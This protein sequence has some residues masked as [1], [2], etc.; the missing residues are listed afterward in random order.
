M[1]PK[2]ERKS[3]FNIAWTKEPCFK[4]WLTKKDDHTGHC[5]ICD[6][7]IPI[8]SHARFDVVRHSK[9]NTHI[10]N[11]PVPIDDESNI[12]Q[13]TT[14]KEKKNDEEPENEESKKKQ[15]SI[16][17]M[18]E[19]D[20]VLDAEIRWTLKKIESKFSARSCD[21]VVELFKIMFS[22]SSI[23]ENMKLKRTK[24]GY[25]VRHGLGPYFEQLLLQQVASS[26]VY[27]LSFDESMNKHLQKGQMD[28]IIRFWNDE[29]KVP[30]TRY[31]TSEFMG[32]A[33]ADDIEK[34]FDSAVTKKLKRPA[35]LIQISSDGP[36]VNLLF[37]KNYNDKRDFNELPPLLNIGT[38]GLH[39]VHG[40]MKAGEK[41]TGWEIGKTL[42]AMAGLLQ[43]FPARRAKYENITETF[44]F[45]LPYCGHRWCE[46][47]KCLE[48]ADEIWPAFIK[49][50]KYLEKEPKSKQ[51]GKGEGKQF[52][53]LRKK[54][55]DPLIRAKMK[56]L[57]YVSGI[58]NEFLRGFQTDKPMVPFLCSTLETISRTLMGMFVNTSTMKNAYTLMSL[59]K[60]D[61]N[62]RKI[63]KLAED[64]DVGIGAKLYIHKYKK[65]AGFKQ[66]KLNEFFSGAQRFLS[67]LL[68]HMMK[69]SPLSQAFARHTISINPNLIVRKSRQ[70]LNIKYFSRILEK[71]VS[72]GRI[73]VKEGNDA[74][75][76]YL[77]LITDIVPLNKEK[78]LAFD[79]FVDRLDTFYAEFLD[80]KEFTALWKVFIIIF[81]LF[82]GQSAIE[83]GFNVNDALAVVNQ[84][85]KSLIALRIVDDYMK[86]QGV[87][88]GTIKIP[89]NLRKSFAGARKRSAEE[90]EEK[91]K[92]KQVSEKQRKRKIVGD[93]IDEVKKKK[94]F[95]QQTIESLHQ[96]A[97]KCAREA[98]SQKDF[99]LLE[100]S[101]DMRSAIHTKAKEIEELE[102]IEQDLV[103]RR[104]GIM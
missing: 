60:I 85:D 67:A 27:S 59:L 95:L 6:K 3:K 72:T 97:D 103:V 71:L 70:E 36:N 5:R 31:L 15:M 26:P 41:A 17:C 101:N 53:L 64:T 33:K 58:L 37:L 51:P 66:E 4:G 54:V 21:N 69:K 80:N 47:E 73:T 20:Q 39:T 16:S 49:F 93:E 94:L 79:K 74:T 82:H 23:A 8:A 92:A 7:D 25:V 34:K 14:V 57:E 18:M 28:I 50:V 65:S 87:N 46:N 55:G 96:D 77:K 88:A 104:E 30:E 52:L 68:T 1:A 11:A 63:Y 83:R 84:C 56:F 42:K 102:K 61:F 100:K 32:E 24:C 78:F 13:F 22:D 43:D 9:S 75:Q 86:T 98:A 48:R 29:K 35:N 44:I 81:V 99:I 90:S 38:C 2:G 62:N 45:P 19:K 40:S 91:D 76:Q 10:K 89:T 12:L